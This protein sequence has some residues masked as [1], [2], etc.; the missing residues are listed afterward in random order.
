MN[1]TTYSYTKPAENMDHHFACVLVTIDNAKG[2][3]KLYTFATWTE[4]TNSFVESIEDA[5]ESVKGLLA[6]GYKRDRKHEAQMAKD[7][8]AA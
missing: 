6:M 7:R 4:Y 3:A 2:T 1:T 5:R 8:K